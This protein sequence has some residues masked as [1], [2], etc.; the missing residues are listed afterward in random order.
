[1]KVG[2]LGEVPPPVVTDGSRVYFQEGVESSN[3]SLA[4]VSVEGGEPTQLPLPF[5]VR[6]MHDISSRSELLL[7]AAPISNMGPTLWVLPVPGGQPRRVG[8]IFATD[9][10]WSP[11]GDEIAYTTPSDLYRVNR[12]GSNARKLA[13]VSGAPFWPRWSPD[14]SLLRFS[15]L[16]RQLNTR[17]LWEVR[18]DGSHFHQLLAGWNDPPGECCGGWTPD[19]K[20]YVF[21]SMHNGTASLWAMR[22]KA[23]FWQ[24]VTR[25]P[26]QLAVGT[27][28]VCRQPLAVRAGRFSILVPWRAA[29]WSVTT[30]KIGSSFHI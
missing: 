20:Y 30:T 27:S 13:S 23:G 10:A 18:A 16:D 19:G 26:F 7:P 9:A 5:P 4:Q 14:G 12:E 1:M 17:T 25:Q 15:V 8:K 11:G 6:G 3:L 21:Q 28:T 24:K 29:N 2:G 22:E